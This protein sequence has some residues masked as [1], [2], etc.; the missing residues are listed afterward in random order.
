MS[1]VTEEE[2]FSR[3]TGKRHEM[4]YTIIYQNGG[5]EQGRETVTTKLAET[6]AY[7]DDVV[8]RAMYDRVEI[9]DAEDRLVGHAPHTLRVVE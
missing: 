3:C 2:N 6:Q 5:R 1:K 8:A 7:A 4:P 9:R